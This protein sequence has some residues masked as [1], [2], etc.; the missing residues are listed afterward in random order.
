MWHPVPFVDHE[1]KEVPP[2]LL[3]YY[4]YPH[5]QQKAVILKETN[6]RGYDFRQVEFPLYLP[7]EL[8][9]KSRT[10]WESEVNEIKK[11]NEKEAKDRSLHYTNRIDLYLPKKRD[12][13]KPTIVVSPILGGNMVVDVF[14]RFFARHG[15]VAAIVHRKKLQ[16]DGKQD[17]SQF[18]NYMR[19]SIIRIREAIDWLEVQPEVDSQKMA[20]FG[21]SYGAILHTVLAAIE[22][23]LKYHILAMPAGPIPDVILKC[24]DPGVTKVV[25][26]AE[27]FG[28]KRDQM[29]ADLQ[30]VMKTDPTRF[31]PYIDKDRVMVFLAL[32]DRVVGMRRTYKLWKEMGRP[33]LKVIPL[34]HYGGLLIFPYLEWVSLRFFNSRF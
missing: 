19:A 15:F 26:E 30:A 16:F 14:A 11:T 6:E 29:Y 21:I 27:R 3:A 28:W 13:A 20:G 25:R 1:K 9:T 8:W 4:D 33:K 10:Q 24:P 5:G 12:K 22:P 23:R 31:A 18:E 17:M 32:F 7:D 34:G 2:D